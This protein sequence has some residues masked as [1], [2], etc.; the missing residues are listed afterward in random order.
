MFI[1][2]KGVILLNEL[3]FKYNKLKKKQRNVNRLILDK[4]KYPIIK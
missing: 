1:K 4:G 2:N 3:L